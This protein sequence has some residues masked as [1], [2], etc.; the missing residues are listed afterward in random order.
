MN[1]AEEI[2]KTIKGNSYFHRLYNKCMERSYSETLR[3]E[4]NISQYTDKEYRDLLRFA[5]LLSST[6]DSESRN[7]AYKIIT[8]LN[9]HYKNDP[10]YRTISKSVFYNLGNFPAVKYLTQ[11]DDNQSELPIDRILQVE[12]KKMIQQVPDA[13][14]IYFT[15]TQYDLFT[16]LSNSRNFSFSGPTS[17]GKSFIIKAFINRV[18]QNKPPE[19]IVIVVPS[20]ALI[21]QFAIEIH[22][23]LGQQLQRFNYKVFTN[24]NVS[25]LVLEANVKLILVLTPERLLSYLSQNENPPIGFLF[26]DEAHKIAQDDTRSITSYVAIEKTLKKY[27]DAKLYFS[28]P[29]VSNPEVLLRLF[30]RKEQNSFQTDE[31]TVTQN[32][33]LADLD[34]QELSYLYESEFKT[35]SAT[36]PQLAATVNGFLTTFG[37]ESNLVYCNSPALTIQYAK[38]FADL[39]EVSDNADLR[40]AS[41]VIKQYIHRDY[42]LAELV[43]KGVA[44]HFGNMPQLIRNLIEKLYRNGDIKYVFC[45]STLLEGVN[46]PTQNLFI[47]DNKQGRKV[48]TPIDFWNLAGR[49]GRMTKELQ[50][51]VFCVKHSS[52]DWEEMGFISNKKI[53]LVPTVYE[54]LNSK[55]KSIE[56][57]IRNGE[58]KSGTEEEKNIL[59]YIANIICIDTM[60]LNTDYNSP[61]INQLIENNK[62]AIIELAKG[63]TDGVEIPSSVLS[64]NESINIKIQN[65]VYQQIRQK[66]ENNENIKFPRDVD[67]ESCLGVLQNFHSLYNWESCGKEL[68][69]I[70]SMKYYA[71][72]MC[73]WIKGESLNQIITESINYY[74]ESSKTIQI[75]HNNYES[76]SSSN[77]LHINVL[78]G[79][80]IKD[81]ESVLRFQFEK[82]FN[83]YY[84]VIK[85]ILGEENAGENWASL[86]EYGTRN[87]IIIALQN[88]GLSRHSATEIYKNHRRAIN[89]EGNQLKSIN[90]TM[91]LNELEKNT[92]EYEEVS[93]I[94]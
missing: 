15:D 47:L 68:K 53:E 43:K 91:L 31:T 4:S 45:T 14:D 84:M 13:E 3:L 23:E 72:L 75:G 87:K 40:T 25:E 34:R 41:Y 24:S 30:Q 26:V 85:H 93:S 56:K 65:S 42:Y 22:K 1:V 32:M 64:A 11:T 12:A 70:N 62:A 38:E 54:R 49:A 77:K 46:M 35:I 59:R 2:S 76:F 63:C 21:N 60:Q 20:R 71:L 18:I 74:S 7:Y 69:N 27:P 33:F 28:S 52:C 19:N 37:K 5:D 6:T 39:I 83:H 17:M 90:K 8:Y 16:K 67:Y 88:V 48:L 9:S 10:Y 78:I 89:I 73:Q 86:L 82:Y 51:N 44:Y 58:I 94:L 61:I 36:I 79:G 50:G 81:I 66:N 92:L 80:I 29:N 55:L 57:Q